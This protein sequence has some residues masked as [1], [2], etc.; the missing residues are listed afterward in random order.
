MLRNNEKC[1]MGLGCV[2]LT[3]ENSE[4]I[5]VA[6]Q[7][8]ITYFDTSDCYGQDHASEIALGERLKV[9]PRESLFISTKASVSFQSDGVHV[10]GSPAYLKR[11]CEN[12]LARLQTNYLDL[13]YLHRIDPAV[14]IE[15]SMLAMKSLVEARKIKSIGLSEVTAA[16][17]C[18]AHKVHPIGAVQIEYSPWS[19]E[20]EVNG[21]ISTCQAL[22]ITVV[23]YSPLGRAFFTENDKNYFLT[24]QGNDFRKMLPRYNGDNLRANQV[25]KEKIANFAAERQLTVAQVV[26]AWEMAKGYLVIPGATRADHFN[27]NFSALAVSFS[28][29]DIAILDGVIAASQYHGDRYPSKK[30]S[31]I[32]TLNDALQEQAGPYSP[33]FFRALTLMSSG[34]TEVQEV[35]SSKRFRA[36]SF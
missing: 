6:I 29:K 12:S 1:K 26:L 10:N 19:R 16:Q 35:R 25:Q 4:I 24:M 17:I 21:V 23:A 20:D 13:F 3:R 33:T 36:N 30:V 31:G 15:A 7:K 27:E 5:D 2:D 18:E 11:A 28:G 32:F 9:Y 34:K 22:G 14:P 8:G